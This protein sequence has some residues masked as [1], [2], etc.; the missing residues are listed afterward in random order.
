MIGGHEPILRENFEA[1]KSYAVSVD[2]FKSGAF[3]DA[4]LFSFRVIAPNCLTIQLY[5]GRELTA[6]PLAIGPDDALLS[7]IIFIALPDHR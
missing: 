5:T 7:H 6:H 1:S 3:W 2:S 4:I